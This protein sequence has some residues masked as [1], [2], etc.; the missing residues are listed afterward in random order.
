ML[1]WFAGAAK[2][3]RGM[4]MFVVSET[5]DTHKYEYLQTLTCFAGL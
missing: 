5:L 3:F 4:K 1:E 2:P